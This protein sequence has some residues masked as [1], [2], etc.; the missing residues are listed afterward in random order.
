MP[1]VPTRPNG[2]WGLFRES[3]NPKRFYGLFPSNESN[4]GYRV[5]D[6]W[7]LGKSIDKQN[8]KTR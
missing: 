4:E 6:V 7:G 8:E 5:A 3:D 2:F 1:E